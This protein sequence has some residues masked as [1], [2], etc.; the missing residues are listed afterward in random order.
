MSRSACVDS[1]SPAAAQRARAKRSAT[2]A[3]CSGIRPGREPARAQEPLVAL[4]SARSAAR[5]DPLEERLRLGA[6]PERDRAARQ[7]ERPLVLCAAREPQ[8][9]ERARGGCVVGVLPQQRRQPLLGLAGPTQRDEQRSGLARGRP[10]VLVFGERAI[11]ERER[12]VVGPR[13]GLEARQPH[14]ARAFF[15]SS[16]SARSKAS[17]TDAA[18]ALASCE[19]ASAHR[20]ER[21]GVGVLAQAGIDER[22]A[23]LRLSRRGQILDDRGQRFDVDRVAQVERLRRLHRRERRLGPVALA[24][25]L[26]ERR[27]RGPAVLGWSRIA[28]CRRHSRARGGRGAHVQQ[29]SGDLFGSPA[30]LEL[31]R[32]QRR[33][34]VPAAAWRRASRRYAS[35]AVTSIRIA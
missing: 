20:E 23:F 5:R 26:S 25:A 22:E 29:P 9:R 11:V 8:L 6:A 24:N 7:L 3:R 35:V 15:A 1:R 2:T 18:G 16:A 19:R 10:I 4:E 27:D 21:R 12:R 33:F 32:R 31:Q 17:R 14:S 34:V 13:V 30:G 28:R